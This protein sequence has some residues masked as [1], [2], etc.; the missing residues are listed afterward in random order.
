M[1]SP[2][3]QSRFTTFPYSPL[4]KPRDC[5]RKER[6]E[7]AISKKM[8]CHSDNAISDNIDNTKLKVIIKEFA[9][10]DNVEKE[11]QMDIENIVTE[12]FDD[13]SSDVTEPVKEKQEID[14]EADDKKSLVD[15]EIEE[16]VSPPPSEPNDVILVE[17]EE[18]DTEKAGS[19]SPSPRP[20]SVSPAP[21]QPAASPGPGAAVAGLIRTLLESD[22]DPV[23]V[24]WEDKEKGEFKVI[25]PGLLAK[26]IQLANP[27]RSIS[28]LRCD[29]GV[30]ESVPGKPLV[31]RFGSLSSSAPVLNDPSSSGDDKFNTSQTDL[32]SSKRSPPSPLP[33][34][35]SKRKTYA[36]K[37]SDLQKPIP[38][39]SVQ[40]SGPMLLQVVPQEGGMSPLT[41]RVP[42]PSSLTVASSPNPTLRINSPPSIAC[43]QRNPSMPA[44]IPLTVAEMPRGEPGSC[45][46]GTKGLHLSGGRVSMDSLPSSLFPFSSHLPPSLDPRLGDCDI[47][48][49]DVFRT[50]L[51]KV[52]Q[53][54]IISGF[55]CLEENLPRTD[56]E[57]E[58]PLD[59]SG[60]ATKRKAE[61]P[62]EFLDEG[63]KVRVETKV[64]GK[65]IAPQ[66]EV[67]GKY[68][69]AK[70]ESRRASSEQEMEEL[71]TFC[72][73]ALHNPDY[74]PRIIC[75]ETIEDGE[76]RIINQEEFLKSF[77]EV[78]K[79]KLLKEGLKKRVRACDEAGTMHSRPHTRLGY[80]FGIMSSDWRPREG[81]LVEQGRRMVP[82]RVAWN[83]SRFRHE[84]QSVKHE[85]RIPVVEPPLFT[86]TPLTEIPQLSTVNSDKKS[87]VEIPDRKPDTSEDMTECEEFECRLVLPR[88]R[89]YH[90]K[91]RL[92]DGLSVTLDRAVFAQIEEKMREAVKPQGS[93]KGVKTRITSR[94]RNI[95]NAVIRKGRRRSKGRTARKLLPAEDVMEAVSKG[96]KMM[97]TKEK[98]DMPIVVEEEEEMLTKIDEVVEDKIKEGMLNMRVVE[99]STTEDT[100]TDETKNKTEAVTEDTRLED[101]K[102]EVTSK[103]EEKIE[104]DPPV[105]PNQGSCSPVE[106]RHKLPCV[107]SQRISSLPSRPVLRLVP[108]SPINLNPVI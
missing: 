40:G 78:R 97:D 91:L 99:G 16:P 86:V 76:F 61:S 15:V 29:K 65:K 85:E 43:P 4:N 9:K 17:D 14:N 31:F 92:G 90:A 6:C 20:S 50:I 93:G 87:L 79:T 72:R 3:T 49:L 39:Q 84:F 42:S 60:K 33:P 32:I 11:V 55:P 27:A 67:R 44:L 37:I 83:S 54:E 18:N 104:V 13:H 51:P 80:R 95:A 74:N 53:P 30:F 69:T 89:G 75:W 24:R 98:Y 58:L 94:D 48:K 57:D 25:N 106:A 68:K 22:S 34:P 41:L 23:V 38:G 70:K 35:P 66:S 96:T 7:S 8:T 59:L 103:E 45:L 88:H 71:W 1:L 12:V 5:E 62:V 10:E 52:S 2:S 28:S 101:T 36:Q 73:A 81:E 107:V 105:L 102:V 77:E 47:P 19:F 63:K 46:P 64:E 108:K 100:K 26:Q 82:S 21:I 56:T